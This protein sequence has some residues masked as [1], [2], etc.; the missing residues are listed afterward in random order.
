MSLYKAHESQRALK[1]LLAVLEPNKIAL[2][3]DKI[4]PFEEVQEAFEHMRHGPIG[5][6]LV[7]PINE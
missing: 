5:K 7:G 4:F 3:I 6:V 1:E 2:A